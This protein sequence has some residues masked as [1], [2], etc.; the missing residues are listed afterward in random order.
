MFNGKNQ[1][2]LCKAAVMKIVEDHINSSVYTPNLRIKITEMDMNC[3]GW[4]MVFHM[5]QEPKKEDEER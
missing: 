1:I 5:E 3:S 4:T 2:T